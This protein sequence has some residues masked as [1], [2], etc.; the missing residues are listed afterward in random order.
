MSQNLS[1]ISPLK[2]LNVGN[3][4]SAGIV[5]YRS[6][7]K[8][9]MGV[10]LQGA[11]WSLLPFLALLPIGLLFY[12]LFSP[13]SGFP[14]LL[15]LLIPVWLFFLVFCFAKYLLYSALL[16]RLAFNDLN[17]QP[18]TVREARQQLNTRLWSF[19]WVAIL[20]ALLMLC[21]YLGMAFVVGIS[22]LALTF[23]LVNLI[24][25]IAASVIVGIFVLLGI[26]VG[27]TWFFSR[28]FISEVVLA[29]EDGIDIGRSVSRSWELTEG[30]V[31]R[32]QGVILIAFLITL[33]LLALTNYIPSIAL[34]QIEPAS[35][36]YFVVYGISL[37][38]SFIG[39]IIVFPFW[40]S[41]KSVLYY[42]LRNRREGFGLKLRDS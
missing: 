40:Q 25:D 16:A 41:V 14:P 36:T 18:E 6:H 5:L 38:T 32:I 2:P 29:A 8:S 3:V 34:T 12:G 4:V 15:W 9:Y 35:P 23:I 39:W 10:A 42:D 11:L 31:W 1:P 22:A 30:S 28:W 19:F 24:G 37:I 13:D 7:L 27:L 20:V 33:P 17:S 21:A 26:A